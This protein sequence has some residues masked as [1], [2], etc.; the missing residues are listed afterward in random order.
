MMQIQSVLLCYRVLDFWVYI[1]VS[2]CVKFRWA[3]RHPP[4]VFP[5]ILSVSVHLLRHLVPLEGGLAHILDS[6]TETPN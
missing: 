1:C 6:L 5:L 2:V 4:G 3:E